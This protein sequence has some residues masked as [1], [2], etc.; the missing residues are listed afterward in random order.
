MFVIFA[1]TAAADCAKCTQVCA[2]LIDNLDL[3]PLWEDKVCMEFYSSEYISH[4]LGRHSENLASERFHNVINR[5]TG[6]GNALQDYAVALQG[7]DRANY[8]RLELVKDVPSMCSRATASS[9]CEAYPMLRVFTDNDDTVKCSGFEQLPESEWW[10]NYDVWWESKKAKMAGVDQACIHASHYVGVSQF[11]HELSFDGNVADRDPSKLTC[12]AADGEPC[13][14]AKT[15]EH[16]YVVSAAPERGL[17]HYPKPS[18]MWKMVRDYFP[19]SIRASGSGAANHFSKTPDG[20]RGSSWIRAAVVKANKIYTELE[21]KK[22]SAHGRHLR[23][24]AVWVGDDGQGDVLTAVM[25]S[26]IV[27]VSFIHRVSHDT[28]NQ[29][30]NFIDPLVGKNPTKYKLA[31]HVARMKNIVYFNN[32]PEAAELAVELQIIKPAAAARVHKSSLKSAL[33]RACCEHVACFST[34]SHKADNTCGLNSSAAVLKKIKWDSK[35]CAPVRDAWMYWQRNHAAADGEVITCTQGPYYKPVP[36]GS[37][38]T[39]SRTFSATPFSLGIFLL[40][41]LAL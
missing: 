35:Y 33:G 20:I 30:W 2:E 37:T 21:N 38:D 27:R 3:N 23:N 41:L 22:S 14:Q 32:Y 12:N 7:V 10:E 4:F 16:V 11:F 5:E 9:D 40:S 19:G 31:D 8:K 18:T 36:A 6:R 29:Q 15:G 34:A 13:G 24:N 39:T 26:D 28:S 25:V 17:H 1:A